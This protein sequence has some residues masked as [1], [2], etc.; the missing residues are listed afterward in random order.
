[1]DLA[2]ELSVRKAHTLDTERHS[3]LTKIRASIQ[4]RLPAC[5]VVTDGASGA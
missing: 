2:L 5:L 4:V 1:M 3:F